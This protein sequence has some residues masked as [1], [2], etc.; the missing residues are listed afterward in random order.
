MIP[1]ENAR[2]RASLELGEFIKDLFRWS[3]IHQG[4][5]G[6]Y[7][8]LK[9]SRFMASIPGTIALHHA[10]IG[11]VAKATAGVGPIRSRQPGVL[12]QRPC[13]LQ[14]ISYF[15]FGDAISGRPIRSTSIVTCFKVLTSSYNFWGTVG[16]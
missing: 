14:D 11:V 2:E 8:S 15:S 7:M 12:K 1:Q 6:D 4:A 3:E 13:T 5:E 9:V 10:N 16:I